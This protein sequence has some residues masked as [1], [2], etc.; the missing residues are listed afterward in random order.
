MILYKSGRVA[1][2]VNMADDFRAEEQ[3]A[4][5]KMGHKIC[6]KGRGNTKYSEMVFL[7]NL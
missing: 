6:E 7:N 3:I 5:S 2:L 1:Q 4:L